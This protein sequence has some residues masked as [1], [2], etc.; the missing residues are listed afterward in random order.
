[1]FAVAFP[2]GAAAATLANIVELHV[3]AYK[4]TF[5]MRRPLYVEGA[6]DIGSWKLV[7]RVFSWVAILVN[8]LVVAY[9]THGVRDYVVIPIVASLSD[10]E[11]T[12]DDRLI[13]DEARYFNLTTSWKSPC[14]DNYR[15]CFS[16]I[17]AVPWLPANRYLNPLE[18]TSQSYQE[19]GL[20]NPESL[21]Y[22]EEHCVLCRH[23]SAET[24]L[25]LS[26]FVIIL[27]HLLILLKVGMM[28]AVPNVPASIRKNRARAN[29]LKGH[30]LVASDASR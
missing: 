27:E 20:C 30:V 7:M 8:V 16:D 28:I 3:D 19:E 5:A 15:N 29:F 24:Y 18:E 26:W 1:M 25:G 22:N 2:L 14:A 17:G 6:D 23:R 13:S 12:G 4:F 11:L 9:A 21:L 10:C